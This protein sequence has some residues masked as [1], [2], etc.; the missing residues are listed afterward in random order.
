MMG[1][2]Y[3]TGYGGLSI[4]PPLSPQENPPADFRCQGCGDDSYLD[5]TPEVTDDHYSWCSWECYRDNE[6]RLDAP[7]MAADLACWESE[8]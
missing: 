4:E 7:N 5:D 1:H 8:Q 3:T 6:G 2:S